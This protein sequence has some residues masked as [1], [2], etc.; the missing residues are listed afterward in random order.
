MTAEDLIGAMWR[1]SQK[2]ARLAG[3]CPAWAV[4]MLIRDTRE[5]L[6]HYGCSKPQ[7]DEILFG[8]YTD[9]HWDGTQPTDR[10][11]ETLLDIELTDYFRER[12]LGGLPS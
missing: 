8:I 1:N 12:G 11:F 9:V 4:E 10:I 7:A 3:T 2:S 5:I 6:T